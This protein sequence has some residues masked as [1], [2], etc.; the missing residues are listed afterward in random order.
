M[1]TCKKCQTKKDQKD[2]P[3]H[4]TRAGNSYHRS[5]CRDC[6]N[7]G[8]LASQ[9]KYRYGITVEQRDEMFSK[10]CEVCGSMDRLNIDHDHECCAG[11]NTCGDCIRGVLCYR[12]NRGE[13]FFQNWEEFY[14]M[15]IY[16]LKNQNVIGEVLS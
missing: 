3:V 15:E 4:K 1:I 14:N 10:G 7:A 9:I 5:T 16:L 8:T 11:Q 2:Y 13:G 6:F 12:H